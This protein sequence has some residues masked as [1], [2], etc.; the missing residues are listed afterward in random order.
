[1]NRRELLKFI[2]LGVIGHTLDL[3]KL[4]WIPGEKKIFLPSVTNYSDY[5]IK[6]EDLIKLQLEI[7]MHGMDSIIG[8]E[9][10]LVKGIKNRR[11][12]IV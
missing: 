6:Y 2:S 8:K 3:D 5:I 10:T 12:R 4:L 1:M 7:I 9:I 11:I